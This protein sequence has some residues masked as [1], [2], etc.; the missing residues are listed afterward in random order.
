MT[1]GPAKAI[2]AV[3]AL[4]ALAKKARGRT[5]EIYLDTRYCVFCQIIAR[6]EP[7]DIL[8]ED[9]DVMVFRNLLLWAPVMLL[10]V[11]K[12]HMT[13]TQLWT[14]P[15]IAKVA[16]VAAQIGAQH[17]RSGFRLL[18]NFGLHALQSQEHGHMHI[19][20]GMRLGRYA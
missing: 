13:Q 9:D 14:D 7:A 17:S 20:G 6:E 1:V 8:Y 2:K 12:Q 11:P 10:A 5:E 18:A 19:I 16:K 4:G 3:P 15:I